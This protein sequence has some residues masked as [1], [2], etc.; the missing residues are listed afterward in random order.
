M[1][2]SKPVSQFTWDSPVKE[3]PCFFLYVCLNW[4]VEQV[5]LYKMSVDNIQNDFNHCGQYEIIHPRYSADFGTSEL[6]LKIRH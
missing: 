5:Y 3:F 2:T 6:D 1:F 4:N